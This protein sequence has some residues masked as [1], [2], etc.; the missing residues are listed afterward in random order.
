MLLLVI[1]ICVIV[2]LK[3]TLPSLEIMSEWSSEFALSADDDDD[4]EIQ[5]Q[6][7]L[8]MDIVTVT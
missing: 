6:S 8:D 2:D 7:L 4:I 1:M 3:R 5:I